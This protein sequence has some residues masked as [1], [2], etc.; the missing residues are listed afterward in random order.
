MFAALPRR[1]VK[2]AFV[3]ELES[4]D[5][6]DLKRPARPGRLSEVMSAEK[7]MAT[8]AAAGGATGGA[9]AAR[10]PFGAA[11]GRPAPSLDFLAPVQ[12]VPG[13]AA[14][15]EALQST[16][17]KALHRFATDAPLPPPASAAAHQPGLIRRRPALHSMVRTCL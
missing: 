17:D 15:S 4:S 14:R 5:E 12:A 6:P 16:S 1:Q 9:T 7:P 13:H 11:N 8:T 3:T 10:S 2:R